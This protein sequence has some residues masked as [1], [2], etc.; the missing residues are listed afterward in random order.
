MATIGQSETPVG[1]VSKHFTANITRSTT[2]NAHLFTL[3]VGTTL[4]SVRVLGTVDSNAGTEARISI[5]CNSNERVFLSEYNVATNGNLQ[6]YPSSV[7]LLGTLTDANPINVI[8]RYDE[9]G[10]A[11]TVG[12]P[13]VVDFETL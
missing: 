13:W 6:A 4:L 3:P 8:G 10:D 12:G 11:S 2:S 5:G 1:S 7:L 9:T